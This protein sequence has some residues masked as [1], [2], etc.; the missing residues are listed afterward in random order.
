MLVMCFDKSTGAKGII[1]QKVKLADARLKGDTLVTLKPFIIWISNGVFIKIRSHRDQK[2][3][4]AIR[5]QA[6]M[7]V[8]DLKISV[9]VINIRTQYPVDPFAVIQLYFRIP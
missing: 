3:R 1:R 2:C 7:I 6:N 5:T 9:I 4:I 8:V